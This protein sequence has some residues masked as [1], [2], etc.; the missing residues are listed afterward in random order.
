MPKKYPQIGGSLLYTCPPFLS[1]NYHSWTYEIFRGKNDPCWIFTRTRTHKNTII[2][3]AIACHCQCKISVN[4]YPGAQPWHWRIRDALSR[5]P[6]LPWRAWSRA[7]G[8]RR[9][10]PGRSRGRRS[11]NPPG[12][13][14]FSMGRSAKM[15]FSMGLPLK[16]LLKWC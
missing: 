9:H 2:D 7:P 3:P 12:R 14:F 5:P 11:R 6:Q 4:R 10:L 8:A 16:L 1:K 15:V 13:S